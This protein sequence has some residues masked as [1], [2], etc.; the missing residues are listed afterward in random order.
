M[1]KSDRV[2]WIDGASWTS[3]LEGLKLMP[4]RQAYVR[5]PHRRASCLFHHFF[6]F[7]V[8]T[9]NLWRIRLSYCP[10]RGN[11]S[12]NFL[13]V[14]ASSTASSTA[15]LARTSKVCIASGEENVRWT[16][17]P[18]CSSNKIC[19]GQPGMYLKRH[20]IDCAMCWNPSE[21]T[22]HRLK[23]TWK[24]GDSRGTTVDIEIM[25]WRCT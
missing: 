9:T 3:A 18:L 8:I 11:R 13:A 6:S 20:A 12:C 7:P 24:R 25:V 17:V 21:R 5:H 16:R 4:R 2:E 10:L 23:G 15:K 22:N 19:K 1:L 14:S